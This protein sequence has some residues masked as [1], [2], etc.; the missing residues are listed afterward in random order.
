MAGN[1]RSSQVHAEQARERL[2]VGF[3]SAHARESLRSGE[4]RIFPLPEQRLDFQP[5]MTLPCLRFHPSQTPAAEVRE[6]PEPRS[7]PPKRRVTGTTHNQP[8]RDPELYIRRFRSS[9]PRAEIPRHRRTVPAR[10]N[11]AALSRQSELFRIAV[12]FAGAMTHIVRHEN[13]SAIRRTDRRQTAHA[14]GV[15]YGAISS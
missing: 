6:P 15:E 12:A 5:S 4:I 14:H 2:P 9:L 11:F 3:Q 7:L 13:S 1:K 10:R 8:T